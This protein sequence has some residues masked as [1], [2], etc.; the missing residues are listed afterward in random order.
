MAV[1]NEL[2]IKIV[3]LLLECGIKTHLRGY[4]YLKEAVELAYESENRLRTYEEIYEPIANTY[5]DSVKNVEKCIR[6]AIMTSLK[7]VSTVTLNSVFKTNSR[8]IS[9]TG[10]IYSIV[11]YLRMEELKGN[12]SKD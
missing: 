7:E 9:N 4:R 3:E 11:E 12:G 2:Y 5:E 6:Y 1:S 8:E 10:Y